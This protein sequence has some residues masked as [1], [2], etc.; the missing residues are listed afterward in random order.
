[1]PW[2]TPTLE[3]L[4]AL[5]RDNVQAKLRSGPM[6]PNSVLRVMSDSNAG[7]AYLVLLYIDW[8]AKQ[9]MPDTA[10]AE[11][12]DRFGNIWKPGGSGRKPATYAAITATASG[13]VGTTVPAFTV[14]YATGTDGATFLFETTQSIVIGNTATAVSVNA[15]TAGPTGLSI[16]STLSA[17]AAI[18]GMNSSL[19]ITAITDGVEEETD[20][21]L[22]TRVLDRIQMPPMGGDADDYVQWALASPGVTRAWCAP[23]EMGIGTCTV[24]IMCDVTRAGTLVINPDGSGTGGGFPTADDLTAAFDYMQTKRPVTVKDFFVEAPIP[25]PINFTIKSLTPDTTANRAA[26]AVNVAAMLAKKAQ[27]AYATNGVLQPAQTIYAAWVSDAI[28]DTL[29]VDHFDLVM[30]DQAMANNGCMAVLGTITYS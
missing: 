6:I 16:G 1:M 9:L 18:A 12:L 20:D 24:R 4:R 30:A 22:R 11:W 27:P 29:G 2:Q 8:L 23:Q 26:I 5:N 25:Q 10:E 3:E 15:I 17:K 7:L 19:T 21:E 13:I 14:L 28:S